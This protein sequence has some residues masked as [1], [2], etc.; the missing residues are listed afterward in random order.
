MRTRKEYLDRKVS[1]R[2][3]YGQFVDDKIKE[4]VLSFI[5]LNRLLKSTD[6]HLND[7][8]CS[9]FWDKLAGFEFR[10][11]TMIKK[12]SY[13]DPALISKLKEAG[14]GVSCAGMVCIYKEAAKQIID[15]INKNKE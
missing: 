7:I 12:P 9:Q 11:S 14:D 4:Q 6:E 2:E 10:G 13:I 5:G 8:S 1:H 3:Y 15:H